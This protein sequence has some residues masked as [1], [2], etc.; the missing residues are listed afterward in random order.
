M[1]ESNPE[2][3]LSIDKIDQSDRPKLEQ[4]LQRYILGFSRF[5]PQKKD[6]SGRFVYP[7]L[8]FYWQEPDRYP[9]FIKQG[10]EICGFALVRVEVDPKS[11]ETVMVLAEFFISEVYRHQGKG[12]QAANILWDQ[13]PSKWK[14]SVMIENQGALLFWKK[15]ITNYTHGQFNEIE[16]KS[17][18]F[19]TFLS[20]RLESDRK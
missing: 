19:Y 16:N 8:Q 6:A 3:L 15:V 10:K 11:N 4:L 7:Y 1:L 18:I 2:S 20:K 9:Y 14:I 17:N 12:Q 13:F 5:S